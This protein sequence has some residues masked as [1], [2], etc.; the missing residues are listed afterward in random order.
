MRCEMGIGDSSRKQFNY[1]KA[2]YH[3]LLFVDAMDVVRNRQ[4]QLAGY[5]RLATEKIHER[6]L[7]MAR[8]NDCIMRKI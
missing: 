8:T 1:Y 5:D 2:V 7:E 6:K 4:N 3:I